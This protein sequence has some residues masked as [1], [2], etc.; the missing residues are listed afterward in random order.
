MPTAA[1]PTP[2]Y[3]RKPA[4]IIGILLFLTLAGSCM[5]MGGNEAAPPP[6]PPAVT[7]PYVAPP[8][9]TTTPP[10]TTPPTTT[11]SD[12]DVY[13]EVPEG[14]DDHRETRFCRGRAWC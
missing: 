1:S 8:T 4:W 6:P 5:G 11:P 14:D 10:T 7:Q 2:A 3:S 13:V 12:T 9:T